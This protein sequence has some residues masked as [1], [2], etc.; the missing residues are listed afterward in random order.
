MTST[1]TTWRAR[2][3]RIFRHSDRDVVLV[4]LALA[5]GALLIS[6][7]SIPLVAIGLWWNANTIAHHFIHRPFFRAAWAN[8]AFS[9]LLTL[10]LGVPQRVWRER[11]L[12]HHADRPVRLTLTRGLLGETALVVSLWTTLAVFAASRSTGSRPWGVRTERAAATTCR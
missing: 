12:A 5:H 8:R 3:S 6:V 11:H 7:P 1:A 4:G 9:G 2:P 10:L